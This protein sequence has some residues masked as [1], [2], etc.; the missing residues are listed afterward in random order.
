MFKCR[1]KKAPKGGVTKGLEPLY[2]A[3]IVDYGKVK[4]IFQRV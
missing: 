1:N 3:I 4:R 2:N